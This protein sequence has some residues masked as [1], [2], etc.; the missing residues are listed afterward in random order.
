MQVKNKTLF[1][2][3]EELTKFT[4]P[5]LWKELN[6]L[7]IESISKI[8]LSEIKV[9]D[10]AGVAFLDEIL[11]KFKQ[12]SPQIVNASDE[13]SKS[14]KTFSSIN[15]EIA[16]P[17]I[18][19]NLFIRIGS[20]FYKF[21]KRLGDGLI[22]TADIAFWSFLGIF[23]RRGQ[24]KGAVVKQSLL[25]GVD[26]LGIVALLSL[27]IGLILALQSAAQLRQYGASIFVAD[28]IAISM[29]REMGPIMTAIM[30]AGRS[31]SAIASEI[32]TMKVTEEIDALK[33]MAI[34]PIRYVVVPKFHA[35][36]ICMPLLV[37][38]STIIGIFGGLI[39]AMTYL[40]LSA[41]SYFTETFK[42]LTLKDVLV[43]LSKSVAFAWVIV[44]IGSYYGFNVKGGAE[45]VGK[46][47]TLSVV[48]SIFSII[49]LDVIFSFIYLGQ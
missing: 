13:I 41:V 6:D 49:V 9:I 3:R 7:P 5:E 40:D 21:L 26:A 36:T 45:G 31:G 33:M 8:D 23:D 4:V 38:L 28:L 11:T 34:N 22:L 42:I 15:L 16:K 1:I 17:P 20:A 44:I 46:A 27:I 2:N 14:I 43:G 18:P 48:A 19:E 10:S 25:I 47:T 39:I 12:F 29:V 37:T 24:R 30:I 32:A 35:I